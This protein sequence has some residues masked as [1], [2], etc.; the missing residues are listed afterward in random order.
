MEIK[1]VNVLFDPAASAVADIFANDIARAI[2][3]LY[4]GGHVVNQ[5]FNDEVRRLAKELQ[6]TPPTSPTDIE[7]AL[8]RNQMVF[9]G[10]NFPGDQ[11]D[12]AVLLFPYLI[13]NARIEFK[14]VKE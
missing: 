5:Y 9:A 8:W 2:W 3:C 14:R 13:G 7:H 4:R 12:F 11:A 10:S 1:T 6:D